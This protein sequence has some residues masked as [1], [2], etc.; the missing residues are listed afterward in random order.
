LEEAVLEANQGLNDIHASLPASKLIVMG[1][2]GGRLDHTLS[3]IHVLMKVS[4]KYPKKCLDTQILL[5]DLHSLML[6]VGPGETKIFPSTRYESAKG[7][8]LIPLGGRANH[9]RT[10]GLRWNLGDY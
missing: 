2:F 8:G 10:T 1:A 4:L 3:T 9:V 6:Y 5:I 7:C